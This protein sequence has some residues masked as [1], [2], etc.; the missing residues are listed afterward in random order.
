[1]ETL[2][3]ERASISQILR[4]IGYYTATEDNF[5][6]LADTSL[7]S[8]QVDLQLIL[9]DTIAPRMHYIRNIKVI[10]GYDP[11]DEPPFKLVDSVEYKDLSILYD[12]TH[13]LRPSV[14]RRNILME[15]GE[16]YSDIR[17]KQSYNLVNSLGSISRTNV[18]YSTVNEGDSALLDY[19]IYLTEGNIH[20]IQTGIDGTNK[21]GNLGIAA[22]ISYNHYNLFNGAEH[23]NIKLRG[24]YEFVKK[25]TDEV[26]SE[27]YYE[28]GIG[29]SLIFPQ[30]HLPLFREYI[31]NRYTTTSEYSINFDIQ[32]RVDYT[33]NF[34]NL[35]WKE[36]FSS[37]NGNVM[38]T[39]SI[40]DIN[41]V[42]MPK[43]SQKFDEYLKEPG[44]ELTRFSYE[45]IFTAGINYSIVLSMPNQ[46]KFGRRQSSFRFFAES[47]GNLLYWGSELFKATKS[48]SGQ[49]QVLN[50]PFAQFLKGDID[51]AQTFR[52]DAKN[53]I[54]GH[55]GLGMA[56]P[57]NNSKIMP[58][59]KRYFAGGPNNVRGWNTR[60]LGPGTVKDTSNLATQVGDINLIM[61]L[62]YRYK[63][64]KYI[65]LAAF[66]DAGNVWTVKEYEN[67]PGGHFKFS[68]F[69]EQ[70]AV[71][72]GIGLRIDLGFIVIRF[73]GGKR[74]YDPAEAKSERFVLFDKFKGN[75][76]F[77]FA[78]GYPF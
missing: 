5:R 60:H 1:M 10:S 3:K 58:F 19:K 55:L 42:M 70:I 52:F 30:L 20:G 66:V 2:E 15:K 36:R 26:L 43:I 63:W 56:Y 54:A 7:M 32:R 12:S 48:E 4:H 33:R 31:T 53:T 65:E 44:N 35:N 64:I 21:A 69:Y 39:Y 46:G 75:A 40:I 71:G 29:T 51:F 61:S 22:N 41:Y 59:E 37:P 57:Y 62:E 9:K 8:N 34:F 49:Y 68:S 50:N 67:Q 23:W 25:S 74:L 73:D 11:F 76:A 45:D 16:R 18:Q 28:F 77:Y 72:C 24:A 17:D 14:L 38:Q 13:F 6:Y 78:I 27:N 47:S